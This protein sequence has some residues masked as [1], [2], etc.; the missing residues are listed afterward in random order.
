MYLGTGICFHIDPATGLHHIRCNTLTLPNGPP[1]IAYLT[2]SHLHPIGA[3]VGDHVTTPFG[4]GI[5]EAYRREDDVHIISLY[6]GT[7]RGYFQRDW[8]KTRTEA[9]HERVKSRC[10]VM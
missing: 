3:A 4:R 10:I 9:T 5:M 8:I 7:T 6:D 2:P 1:V